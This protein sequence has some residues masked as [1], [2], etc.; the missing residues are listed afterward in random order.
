MVIIPLTSDKKI[1]NIDTAL[2]INL[3][4]TIFL[5]INIWTDKNPPQPIPLKQAKLIRNGKG[6]SK[7]NNND[8][9]HKILTD[10]FK[11]IT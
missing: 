1:V 2:V 4:E 9:K 8:L 6:K 10:I 5:K 7:P 11:N 3:L